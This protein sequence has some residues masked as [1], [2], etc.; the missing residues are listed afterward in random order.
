MKRLD[1]D[2]YQV[3][4]LALAERLLGKIFVHRD[5]SERVTRGRIVETEA[6][7][8]NGDEACH[9]WR[10]MTKRNRVM[11]GP[12]GHLYIYFSYGCHYLANIVSEPEGVAGAVLLRAMEPV[13]G[14][15][16]MRER[17]RTVDEHAL[18]SGPGKLTQALGLGPA[19]YGESLIGDICWLE[20]APEIPPELIGTS[21]RIGISRSTEL[22]W[23]KFVTGSPHVS[24]TQSGVASKKRKKG[25]E[26]S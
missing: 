17:R 8:G 5:A 16:W 3:P 1:A 9:A 6:Y 13:E 2:F 19:H 20:E 7:L 11:F 10:G 4:T 26:S 21:P 14:V 25:L 22:P 18:M 15:G 23:R 12:P 24:K